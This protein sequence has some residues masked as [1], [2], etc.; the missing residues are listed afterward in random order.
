MASKVSTKG[1]ALITI[2]PAM[3]AAGLYCLREADL[4]D[5]A[6]LVRS[7]YMAMEYQRLE[8]LRNSAPA[9][10]NARK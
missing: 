9:D 4:M 6:Y 8:E 7:I 5:L 3:E 1:A 10:T 2:S